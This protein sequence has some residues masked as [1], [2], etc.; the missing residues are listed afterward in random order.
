MN[1]RLPLHACLPLCLF[2]LLLGGC[3]SMHPPGDAWLGEDKAK[4]FL[5]A[6]ALGAGITYAV[7]DG[8]GSQGEAAALTYGVV[9]PLGV[10]KE[11]V[12]LKVRG[13]GFSWKDLVWDIL[14]ASAGHLLGHAAAR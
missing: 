1:G 2:G 4:H 10:G 13:T 8:G 3:A 7:E 6:G 14:G 11:V 9:I 12:D 5:V